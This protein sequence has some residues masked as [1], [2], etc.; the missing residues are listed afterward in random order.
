[1]KAGGGRLAA[2]LKAARL[3]FAE[4]RD[5]LVGQA[6]RYGKRLWLKPAL[7]NP[8]T[9][10]LVRF[11]N[12]GSE[13]ITDQAA[14]AISRQLA[15]RLKP[16][17]EMEP[18]GYFYAV[19][20]PVVEQRGKAVVEGSCPLSA[21][22]AEI[23]LLPLD[24]SAAVIAHEVLHLFGARDLYTKSSPSGVEN[25]AQ[26]RPEELKTALS[27]E[28]LEMSVMYR[29]DRPLDELAVDPATAYAVGWRDDIGA[30]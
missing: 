26:A 18:L 21:A 24:S 12:E 8:I 17:A 29:V 27:R 30:G 3:A 6:E 11:W 14:Q 23:C 1:M 4:A 15:S 13:W 10:K 20:T 22:Q 25:P 28:Q 9:F 7:K 2:Q 19:F 16:R 5:F